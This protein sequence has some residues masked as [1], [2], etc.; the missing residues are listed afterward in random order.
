MQIIAGRRLRMSNEAHGDAIRSLSREMR[1]VSSF[2]SLFS[3]AVAERSGMHSTD[4]E[5][6]DLLNVLGPMTAGQLSRMTGLTSGATTRLIDRLA[7]AGFVRR[8]ADPSDRRRVRVEPVVENLD[9]I[10]E[11]YAPLVEALDRS[12]ASFSDAELAVILRFVS[13]TSAIIAS[14][15]ARLRQAAAGLPPPT[16]ANVDQSQA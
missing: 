11:M 10:G 9:S 5:T 15:N 4:I 3:Q 2:D 7:R 14:E 1:L 12:W 8:A 6:L 16:V 13:Q